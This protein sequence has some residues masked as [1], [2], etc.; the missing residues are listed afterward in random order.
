MSTITT[1]LSPAHT[2]RVRAAVALG[3]ALLFALPAMDA[4]ARR[5]RRKKPTPVALPGPETWPKPPPLKVER[6]T[7]DNGLR[8]VVQTDTS[9][10]QVAVG[11]MVDVGSRDEERGRSGLAHFFEHMMFQGSKNVAKMEHFT[12]LEAVGADLNANTSTDRTYYYEVVPKEALRFALWL[13]T[14][15]FKHLT[16]DAKNVENQRQTVMEE[17]R[18]RYG[19]RPYAKSFLTTI[20]KSF[21]D[22][23]LGHST[24][25]SMEDLNA[26]PVEAF[27]AFW[28]KWYTPNNVVLALVGDVTIAEARALLAETLGTLERRAEPTKER[29][30]LTAPEAHRYLAF[31]EPLGRM[32]AF[33]LTWR[34]PALPEDDAYALAIARAVLDGG[35]SGR[36]ERRLAKETGLATRHFAFLHGRREADLLHIFVELSRAD[37]KAFAEAKRIVLE[38]ILAIAEKGVTKDELDRAK[39]SFERA[40]VFGALS[41]QRRAEQLARYELYQGDARRL[42]DVLPRFRAVTADDVQRVVRAWLTYDQAFE[43]DVRPKGFALPEGSGTKPA[44]VAEAE[45][46]IAAAPMSDP[47]AAKDPVDEQ[48]EPTGPAAS[49]DTADAAD[50]AAPRAATDEAPA[51]DGPEAEPEV[52]QEQTP[53]GQVDDAS[54]PLPLPAPADEP[55]P[56]APDDGAGEGM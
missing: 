47:P 21:D 26:A 16:I 23:R 1:Q 14:D 34:V 10:P 18:Q 32:P 20:E 53:P 31:D 43:V 8:V 44:W 52:Q 41:A 38:E 42:N 45:A 28:R 4:D 5:R 7:L 9:A 25:G 15:R 56:P 35:S 11:L 6:F 12:A 51:T 49:A 24:I 2:R 55:T 50:A 27:D 29:F 19:I 22:W 39:V 36:L 3:L 48:A 37:A 13:E 40:F 54:A 33:H 46:R 17:A 30:E